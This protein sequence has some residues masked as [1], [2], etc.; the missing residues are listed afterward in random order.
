MQRRT[1]RHAVPLAYWPTM[2]ALRPTT[3]HGAF[4]TA[5]FLVAMSL[6]WSAWAQDRDTPVRRYS[7]PARVAW[8]LTVLTDGKVADTFS[9]NTAVGQSA[10]VTR[11]WNVSHPVGCEGAQTRPVAFARTITLSPLGVDSHQVIGFSV[12]TQDTI[13][14][15]TPLTVRS[16]GCILPPTPRTITAHH[17]EWDIASG[18]SDTW[19]IVPKHPT[20]AYQLAAHV[21]AS[22]S[23]SA[24]A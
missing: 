12:D 18:Q 4:R 16:D 10:T 13:D 2:H 24:S 8:T 7:P 21:A 3:P 6:T 15:N 17:P 11:Q 5:L 9:G 20:L 23:A 14:D 19:T 22:A 1:A